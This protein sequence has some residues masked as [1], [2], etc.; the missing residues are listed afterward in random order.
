MSRIYVL[1][2]IKKNE[3]DDKSV[4]SIL[5]IVIIVLVALI[6]LELVFQ[7]VIAPNLLVRNVVIDGISAISKDEILKVSGLSKTEY[8]FSLNTNSIDKRI[9]DFPAVKFAKC[10]KVFPDTLRITIVERTPL[11]VA[12]VNEGGRSIPVVFDEDGVI[13]RTGKSVKDT[14]L[15]VFSGLVFNSYAPGARL[16]AKLKPFLADLKTIRDSSRDIFNFVSE[17]KVEPSKHDDFET[18]FYMVPYGTRIRT[19]ASVNAN[20]LTYALMVLDVLKKERID[21]N[22]KE[23]DFRSKEIVYKEQGGV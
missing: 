14:N 20:M 21:R 6:I 2:G 22:V 4:N 12:L 18:V 17:I 16:P 1:S 11:A 23:I 19:A 3:R 15:P 7:F 13:F 5:W 10:E 8:Y 9:D